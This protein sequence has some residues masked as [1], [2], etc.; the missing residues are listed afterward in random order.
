MALRNKHKHSNFATRFSHDAAIFPYDGFCTANSLSLQWMGCTF[1][2]AP[3]STAAAAG[4][5]D[6]QQGMC[7]SA[8]IYNPMRLQILHSHTTIWMPSRHFLSLLR[9]QCSDKSND[10]LLRIFLLRITY[11]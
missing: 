5:L 9:K 3:L 10:I 4:Y 7:L 1:W 6:S 11:L 8:P 2:H